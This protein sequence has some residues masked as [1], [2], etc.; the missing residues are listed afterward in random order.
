M[1]AAKHGRAGSILVSLSTASQG[2]N[3]VISDDGIGIGADPGGGAAMGRGM[4]LKIMQYRVGILGGS[5][6]VKRRKGGGTRVHCICPLGRRSVD[7]AA[8]AVQG[9]RAP[10]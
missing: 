9:A 4:G 7:S 6:Q 8:D 2:V 5:L 1:N 3:L 10:A